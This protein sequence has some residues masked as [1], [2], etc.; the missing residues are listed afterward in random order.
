MIANMSCLAGL[1]YC[2]K[3]NGLSLIELSKKS[4]VCLQTLCSYETGY[5]K[6]PKLDNLHKLT[7][8]LNIDY[9]YL[10]SGKVEDD[11]NS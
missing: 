4:G 2:R 7:K 3:K 6:N 9:N 8:A 5:R 11:C 1:K 10:I